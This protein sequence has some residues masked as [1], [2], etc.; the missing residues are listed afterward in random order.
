MPNVHRPTTGWL[1]LAALGVGACSD[2]VEPAPNPSQESPDGTAF[3]KLE[4]TSK[5][6]TGIV[7]AAATIPVVVKATNAD[8]SVAAG[9]PVSFSLVGP[10]SLQQRLDTTDAEGLASPGTWTL[11]QRTGPQRL[12]ATS[13]S[14]SITVDVAVQTSLGAF[15]MLVA[16]PTLNDGDFEVGRT[17]SSGLRT[18]AVDSFNNRVGAGIQVR[19]VALDGTLI[20]ADSLTTTNASSEVT[21]RWTLATLLGPQRLVARYSAKGVPRA[22]TL[23]VNA[24]CAVKSL[25][26]GA[27]ATGDWLATDC[28][29]ST[30][31]RDAYALTFT[32]SGMRAITLTADAGRTL[33]LFGPRYVQSVPPAYLYTPSATSF[34]LRY[35]LAAG[36]YIVEA[37]SPAL[38]DGAYSVAVGASLI[39]AD[40]YWA[41]VGCAEAGN[42]PVFVSKGIDGFNFHDTAT[43]TCNVGGLGTY[44]DRYLIQLTAGEQVTINLKHGTIGTGGTA[45]PQFVLNL[46]D[47][48]TA[49]GLV[50]A[51]APVPATPNG[52]ATNA[53]AI[54]YTAPSTGVYEIVVGTAA[55]YNVA[56]GMDYELIVQ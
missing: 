32:A 5:P 38:A 46:R 41:R 40:G 26:L 52:A 39:D 25:A 47:A 14:T 20:V 35:I 18:V 16:P 19:W 7:G 54:T 45:T 56:L 48:S 31:R 44:Q 49:G 53:W 55:A 42:T 51:T 24:T 30:Q 37:A 3:V 8:G 27:S 43:N 4:A 29:T 50:V 1:L 17:P 23:T 6:L 11:G 34:G 36:R 21:P 10:G 13:G 2:G 12:I 9:Q 15:A 22:D 33:Q 28:R